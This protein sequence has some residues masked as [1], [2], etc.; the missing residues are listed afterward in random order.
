[1]VYVNSRAIIERITPSG[2]EVVVQLRTKIGE[3]HYEFPGGRVELFES[4]FSTLKRAV[5]EETGLEITEA[6]GQDNCFSKTGK[7]FTTE[8]FKPYLVYQTT[9]GPI[10]SMG[11]YFK[12]K[13]KGDLL[14]GDDSRDIKWITI[15]ELKNLVSTNFSEIDGAAALYYLRDSGFTR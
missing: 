8:C 14:T 15:N 6:T 10:D 1:M 12:C 2:I 3:E 4:L 5:K 9:S 13:A 11:V 7:S